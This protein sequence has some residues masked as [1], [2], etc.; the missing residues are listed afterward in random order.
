MYALSRLRID[1]LGLRSICAHPD[2]HGVHTIRLNRLWGARDVNNRC[3]LLCLA[4]FTKLR[5]RIHINLP[6]LTDSDVREGLQIRNKITGYHIPDTA[7]LDRNIGCLEL[8]RGE[9]F[10]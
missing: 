7:V 6:A 4:T 2:I 3:A 1:H 8:F 9:G 5:K 10:R